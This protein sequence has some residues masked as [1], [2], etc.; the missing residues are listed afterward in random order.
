MEIDFGS[1]LNA[2][3][4]EMQSNTCEFRRKLWIWSRKASDS[5]KVTGIMLPVDVAAVDTSE[6]VV[7]SN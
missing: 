4:V 1:Y 5:T 6:D 7:S 2:M 3:F